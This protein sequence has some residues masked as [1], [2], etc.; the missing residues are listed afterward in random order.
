MY[1][2]LILLTVGL[3][4]FLCG[5]VKNDKISNTP[6]REITGLII[7]YYSD[8]DRKLS[9]KVEIDLTDKGAYIKYSNSYNEIEK[10]FII[11]NIDEIKDFV[12]NNILVSIKKGENRKGNNSDE[13]KVLWRI[14][15]LTEEDSCNYSGFDEYPEYWEELWELIVSGSGAE[16]ISEFRLEE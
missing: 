4:L 7:R 8:S 16:D 9:N 5:C 2:K 1:K 12:K 10:Q 11:Q 15:V 6:D 14:R 13:Q 3:V